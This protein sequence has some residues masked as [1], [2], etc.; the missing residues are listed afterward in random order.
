MLQIMEN[1]YIAADLEKQFS[2]PLNAGWMNL[3]HRWSQTYLLRRFWPLLRNE[4]SRQFVFFCERE[5]ALKT[6]PREMP[7]HLEPLD[8]IDRDHPNCWKRIV[9][10][11][12][13]EWPREKERHGGLEGL[14]CA[15]AIE[16]DDPNRN[17][18]PTKA[19]WYLRVKSPPG[20]LGTIR[21]RR[22]MDLSLASWPFDDCPESSN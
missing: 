20:T 15:D 5:L 11:F 18:E 12:D 13:R 7:A 3:F 2:H 17:G 6:E 19:A 16:Y 21:W 22:A 14:L 1:A 10:E 8:T 9:A 4:Y